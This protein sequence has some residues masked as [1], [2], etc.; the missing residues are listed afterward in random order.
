MLDS[1]LQYLMLQIL[2]CIE[3][4]T[5]PQVGGKVLFFSHSIGTD[6]FTEVF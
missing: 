6:E 2:A 4:A 3:I 1:L 5:L